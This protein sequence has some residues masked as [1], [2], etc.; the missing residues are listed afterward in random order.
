MIELAPMLRGVPYS[1]PTKLT[2]PVSAVANVFHVED[3]SDAIFPPGPS[4][5]VLQG[6]GNRETVRYQRKEGNTLVNVTRATASGD[7]PL[8]WPINTTI[9]RNFTEEDFHV[10]QDNISLLDSETNALE[11]RII[12]TRLLDVDLD[13]VIEPGNYFVQHVVDADTIQN[14][15]PMLTPVV[16][17]LTLQVYPYGEGSHVFRVRQVLTELSTHR[18]FSRI[19]V[20]GDWWDWHQVSAPLPLTLVNGGTGV[21]SAQ[22]L[23]DLISQGQ[24]RFNNVVEFIRSRLGDNVPGVIFRQDGSSLW[25]L[26]TNPENPEGSFNSLRPFQINLLTGAVT[27]GHNVHATAYIP[28]NENSSRV[29]RT[30]WVRAQAIRRIDGIRLLN[31]DLNSV[32]T[33]GN[34]FAQHNADA[35]ALA[36]SPI[37]HAFYM[38]VVRWGEAP[39]A[40]NRV[41][42]FITEFNANRTFVR[43]FMDGTWTA[44]QETTAPT[45]SAL[46]QVN[47][48]GTGTNRGW[49]NAAVVTGDWNDHIATGIYQGNNLVNAPMSS[50]V[51]MQVM[52]HSNVWITQVAYA[53]TNMEPRIFSRNNTNGVWRPWR[54]I[55]TDV[56]VPW[57]APT[58][59]NGWTGSPQTAWFPRYGRDSSGVVYLRG[60]V[61][62]VTALN[63]TIATGLDNTMIYNLPAG[64]RPLHHH[65]FT[66]WVNG[67]FPVE[68]LADASGA[69]SVH[70]PSLAAVPAGTPLN[71]LTVQTSFKS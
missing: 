45:E 50:W 10:M 21:T 39:T 48:G 12:G 57:I 65:T 63:A 69:V 62:K 14:L 3:A 2:S 25:I 28:A 17:A 37:G 20:D 19:V 11:S 30:D 52:H 53:F 15:P 23:R 32:T 41:F 67:R 56:P 1:R 61:T 34:Y 60:W 22:A 36:N 66:G 64:F 47:R 33:P 5:A 42:Q 35:A 4:S 38:Q 46:L 26:L 43:R 54:E 13:D 59:V 6:G 18:Q 40:P 49:G 51:F 29:A 24:L 44:W 31:V 9:Q 8:D 71:F 68:M 70:L 58:L 16:S 55:A 27:M 7:T